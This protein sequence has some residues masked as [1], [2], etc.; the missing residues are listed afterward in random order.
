MTAK[1]AYL[2]ATLLTN[3]IH[4]IRR[5]E[6][7]CKL[8]LVDGWVIMSTWTLFQNDSTLFVHFARFSCPRS[9]ERRGCSHSADVGK[10]PLS[11]YTDL[12]VDYKLEM[13][14]ECEFA[15]PFPISCSVL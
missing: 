8:G 15:I 5:K 9:A 7:C 14:E 11:G 1:S 13:M 3:A 10:G 4:H 6:E 2:S 12:L